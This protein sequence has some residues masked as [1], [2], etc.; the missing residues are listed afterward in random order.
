MSTEESVLCRACGERSA[1][2]DF[3]PTDVPGMEICP[4]CEI[5]VPVPGDFDDLFRS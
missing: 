1:A 3:S 2:D 5:R 4:K